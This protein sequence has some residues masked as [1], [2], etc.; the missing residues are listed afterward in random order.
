M[1]RERCA[2]DRRQVLCWITPAGRALLASLEEPFHAAEEGL[3]GVLPTAELERLIRA[4][5]ALRA[6][7]PE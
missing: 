4:L 3:L 6:A 2:K 7:R 1:R 5:D